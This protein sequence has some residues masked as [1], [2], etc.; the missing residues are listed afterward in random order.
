MISIPVLGRFQ[1]LPSIIGATGVFSQLNATESGRCDRI[2]VT[3]LRSIRVEAR[4]LC[5]PPGVD[6]L[7]LDRAACEDVA[8][9]TKRH[10][11]TEN[12]KVT[13]GVRLRSPS[14]I[15][16]GDIF[17]AW[18]VGHQMLLRA[19][20]SL[21]SRSRSR[22]RRSRPRSQYHEDGSYRTGSRRESPTGAG[23]HPSRREYT[24]WTSPEETRSGGSPRRVMPCYPRVSSPR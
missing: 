18:R 3:S 4:F 9:S 19:F 7:P 24:F 1:C 11:L 10:K 23:I 12:R 14:S 5:P 22:P 13:S 21:N 6:T 8:A 16:T 20:N 17:S 15:P 2:S